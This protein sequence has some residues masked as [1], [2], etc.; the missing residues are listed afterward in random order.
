M[1]R[2]FVM[3]ASRI[4]L[5]ENARRGT[6]FLAETEPRPELDNEPLPLGVKGWVRRT[7]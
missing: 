4:E 2:A 5:L 3:A 6:A 1:F 7:S